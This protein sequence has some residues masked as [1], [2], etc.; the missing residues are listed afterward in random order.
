GVPLAP[1]GALDEFSIAATGDGGA[2][3]AWTDGPTTLGTVRLLRLDA[4][5][6]VAP[7]WPAG[8]APVAS[9]RL[10][11][12][13]ARGVNDGQGGA[14]VA[15][16]RSRER[17]GGQGRG[18]GVG[19]VGRGGRARRAAPAARGGIRRR[20]RPARPGPAH[21]RWFGR[22]LRRLELES[23]VRARRPRPARRRRWLDRHGLAGRR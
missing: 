21:R 20:A 17:G 15:G 13:S 4:G 11:A 5:G 23:L 9:G 18:R 16:G 22:L 6:A 7:G 3:V 10:D 19:G 14:V 2:I 8:G 12:R 1:P